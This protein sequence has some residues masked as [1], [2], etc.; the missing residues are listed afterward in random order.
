MNG[1]FG[2]CTQTQWKS[3]ALL[4]N[5]D[6]VIDCGVEL[7][8]KMRCVFASLCGPGTFHLDKI[9]ILR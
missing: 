6:E 2:L 4:G 3:L 9:I 1:H 5:L 7:H 8:I